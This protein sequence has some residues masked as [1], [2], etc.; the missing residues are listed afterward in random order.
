MDH[1]LSAGEWRVLR[2]LEREGDIAGS[3]TSV[4]EDLYLMGLRG[5]ALVGGT[6]G[7]GRWFLTEAGRKLLDENPPGAFS[8]S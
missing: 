4:G 8:F 1:P 5:R 2:R 3:E 7:H 6:R